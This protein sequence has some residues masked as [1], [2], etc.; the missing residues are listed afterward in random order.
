MFNIIFVS[1]ESR[2][3]L[4]QFQKIDKSFKYIYIDDDITGTNFDRPEYE[5]MIQDV[6]NGRINCII[7]KDLSR[8]AREHIGAGEYLEKVFGNCKKTLYKSKNL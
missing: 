8:F 1:K 3:K 4:Y 7:V 5:R 6:E 2:N